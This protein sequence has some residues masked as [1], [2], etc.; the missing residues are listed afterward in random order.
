MSQKSI[1]DHDNR[2][3]YTPNYYDKFQS[4]QHIDQAYFYKKPFSA[5][6]N[7]DTPGLRY[8]QYQ[9]ATGFGLGAYITK[10][11]FVY[12]GGLIQARKQ[13]IYNPLY[14][15][16]H[17]YNF[18]KGARYMFIGYIIGTLI[19]TFTFGQPFLLEDCIRSKFRA[20]TVAQKLDQGFKTFYCDFYMNQQSHNTPYT[21]HED[22]FK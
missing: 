16:N 20:L 14:F 8:S 22:E 4:Q 7:K 12:L 2:T 18:M 6:Y 21:T 1:I 15:N 5:V 19:S 10:F 9:I 13:F 17:Y 11:G 3:I